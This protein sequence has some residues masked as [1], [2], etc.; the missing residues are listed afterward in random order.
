MVALNFKRMGATLHY[1]NE[2]QPRLFVKL[3]SDRAAFEARPVKQMILDM[4]KVK[5]ALEQRGLHEIVVDTP[6]IM[7]V[8]SG[9][10][11]TTISRDGRMLIKRVSDEDEATQVANQILDAIFEKL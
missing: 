2:A 1:R 11:E 5:K 7:V 3:C 9:K 4:S 8:K 10:A 6:H